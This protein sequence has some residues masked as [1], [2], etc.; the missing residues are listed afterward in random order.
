V[1][2]V[3][4]DTASGEWTFGGSILTFAFPM[5][6]EQTEREQTESEAGE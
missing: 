1:H 6:P 5:A 2:G 4:A 3:I